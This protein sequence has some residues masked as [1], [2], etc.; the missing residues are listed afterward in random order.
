MWFYSDKDPKQFLQAVWFIGKWMLLG[1][2]IGA[3]LLAA[4]GYLVAGSDGLI[5]GVYI[6]LTF[7]AMGGV[8]TAGSRAL[9][10][11]SE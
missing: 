10:R 11:F 8:I 4:I 7:G 1:P 9:S 5:N 3:V 2:V 6:G